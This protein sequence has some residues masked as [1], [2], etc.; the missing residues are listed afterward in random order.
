MTSALNMD[1]SKCEHLKQLFPFLSF[2]CITKEKQYV[3]ADVIVDDLISNLNDQP[4]E[5]TCIRF[6]NQWVQPCEIKRHMWVVE[7]WKGVY[8]VC[9]NVK[10]KYE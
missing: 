4:L 9:Q 5:R 1:K 10:E 3:R 8:N 7:D 6:K 2:I